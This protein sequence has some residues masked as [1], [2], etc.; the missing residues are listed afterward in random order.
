MRTVVENVAQVRPAIVAG[1][2][3]TVHAVTRVWLRSDKL[4]IMWREET[5]PAAT[6]IEFR[7]RGK[8]GRPATDALVC[9]IFFV[10]PIL[11]RIGSLGPLLLGHVILLRRQ[12]GTELSFGFLGC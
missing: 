12:L 3:S 5:R 1:N 8:Q 4:R 6:G 11:A 7:F 2:F 9:A 10:I